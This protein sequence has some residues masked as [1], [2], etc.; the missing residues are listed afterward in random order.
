MHLKLTNHAV[1]CTLGAVNVD[2]QAVNIPDTVRMQTGL[3]RRSLYVYP[4]LF[5]LHA[6]HPISA[7]GFLMSTALMH[8]NRRRNMAYL[9]MNNGGCSDM[10]LALPS[11]F[12]W[13][14][15]PVS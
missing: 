3:L 1:G 8:F 15:F 4:R 7:L 11:G 2:Q 12:F 5:V 14:L 9:G 10:R 13:P 6:T